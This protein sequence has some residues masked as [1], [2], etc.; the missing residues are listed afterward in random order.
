MTE[1][2]EVPR[3]KQVT[4]HIRGRVDEDWGDWFEGLVLRTTDQGITILQGQV[5]DQSAIYGLIS[6]LRDLGLELVSVEQSE[7][8]DE[9]E[10][11]AA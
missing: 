4:I 5:A 6:K 11:K 7:L 1:P 2:V 10:G 3:A 9:E 8:F